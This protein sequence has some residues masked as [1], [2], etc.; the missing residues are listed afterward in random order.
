[1]ASSEQDSDT[2]ALSARGLK[3]LS[4]EV[5][6]DAA[7]E[8]A[9][10]TGLDHGLSAFLLKKGVQPDEVEHFLNPTLRQFLPDP[11]SFK[12]MDLAAGLIVDHLKAEKKIA[13]FADY[14][15]DGATSASQIIRYFRH[16][17]QEPVLYVPD[18]LKEG[19]GPTPE[20]FEYLKSID[21]ELVITVDC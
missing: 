18:R 14:D 7:A 13:V 4:P 6:P 9:R 11:S 15:V 12:D 2:A 1:M 20:A 3:W 10:K 5:D 17:G 19:F 21:V 16:F 8:F